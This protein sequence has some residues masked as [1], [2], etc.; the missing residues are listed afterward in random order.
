MSLFLK[1]T[2]KDQALGT[3][4]VFVVRVSRETSLNEVFECGSLSYAAIAEFLEPLLLKE[5]GE[6]QRV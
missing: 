5:C 6:R 4:E 1:P 2:L 3:F